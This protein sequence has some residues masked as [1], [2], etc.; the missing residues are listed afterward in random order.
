[1]VSV[2]ATQPTPTVAPS[3]SVSNSSFFKGIIIYCSTSISYVWLINLAIDNIGLGVGVGVGTVITSLAFV[4][5]IMSK[6]LLR[7]HCRQEKG[8]Y[9]I[10]RI[11]PYKKI[12]LQN[13]T[14]K[15]Q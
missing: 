1:M 14:E 5:V 4:S 3:A 12:S 2:S 7:R 9:F 8:R 15:C 13:I 6:V 10:V 11:N